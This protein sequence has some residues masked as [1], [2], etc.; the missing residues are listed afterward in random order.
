[1]KAMKIM[2]ILSIQPRICALHDYSSFKRINVKKIVSMKNLLNRPI[3]YVKFNL[4]NVN[5][6]QELSQKLANKGGSS[7]V[8]IELNNQ[9]KLR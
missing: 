3:N 6:L 1:M 8:K 5:T 9:D 4:K 7:E 2:M